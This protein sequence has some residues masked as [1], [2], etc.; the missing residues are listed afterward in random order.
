VVVVPPKRKNPPR[1]VAG[2]FWAEEPTVTK[3]PYRTGPVKR[4]VRFLST[5]RRLFVTKNWRLRFWIDNTEIEIIDLKRDNG[6]SIDFS[7]FAP[8]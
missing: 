7:S 1:M 4:K 6:L 3:T 2:G 5:G 8:K